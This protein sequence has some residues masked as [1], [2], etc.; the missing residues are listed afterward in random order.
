MRLRQQISLE[1]NEGGCGRKTMA[2]FN[3]WPEIL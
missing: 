2:S 1:K 3:F